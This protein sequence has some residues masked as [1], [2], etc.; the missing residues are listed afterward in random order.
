MTA[1]RARRAGKGDGRPLRRK[2]GSSR[3]GA[4]RRWSYRVSA[5]YF[6]SDA[7][8]RPTGRSRSSPTRA[9]PA[10]TVGG[11]AVPGRRRRARPARRSRTAAPAS[12][13]S[14]RASIRN[15]RTAAGITYARRRRRHLRDHPHGH[16]P[17]RH[18]DRDRTSGYG[19]VN[20]SRKRAEGSTPSRTSLSAEAPNLLLVDPTTGKP[21]QLNFSTQ[22]YDFEVGDA[23]PAGRRQVFTYGGNVR[24]NNFDI[25]IAPAAENRTELGALR[26]GRDLLR[27]V[28]L[29]RSAAAWTSSATSSDP[30]V[31]AAPGRGRS[32][33]LRGPLGA[34]VVQPRVPIALGDQQLPRTSPSST[35]GL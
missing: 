34:R 27:P 13:S 35:P 33:R 20:Y 14:T 16:R 9:N 8:P 29:R 23:R 19:E 26:A 22:T 7:F 2:R 21:L 6:K 3:A 31:L 25:T 28:R 10:A 17:V 24:R 12:R 4:E 5:G 30:G 11:A 18:P 15:Y 32:S 1:T